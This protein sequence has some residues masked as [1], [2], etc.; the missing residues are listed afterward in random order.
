M[1]DLAKAPSTIATTSTTSFGGR[2]KGR[3]TTSLSTPMAKLT[4]QCIAN[5]AEE[6]ISV[7]EV[8][9]KKSKRTDKNTLNCIIERWKEAL[10]IPPAVDI[11]KK[12]LDQGQQN[13]IPE[14]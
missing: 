4:K 14:C 5:S 9:R 2:P 6:S 8:E 1:D 11:K 3:T 7:R 10:V 12:K 13:S